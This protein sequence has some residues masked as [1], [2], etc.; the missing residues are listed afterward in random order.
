M[1]NTNTFTGYYRPKQR[2]KYAGD[3]RNIYYRSSWERHFCK[4]C[5]LNDKVKKWAIEPF[6][7]PYFDEGTGKQRKYNPDFWVEM[8]DGTVY[9]IEVKPKYETEPPKMKEG[10]KRF[11]LAEQTFKTNSSKWAAATELCTK[12]GWIFK[13]V[14]EVTLEEMG[15]KLIAQPKRKKIG[16]NKSKVKYTNKTSRKKVQSKGKHRIQR[17]TVRK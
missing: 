8:K 17:R 7:I 12:K 2:S 9:L 15:I 5:D 6:K 10:T 3:A 11:L 4:W 1:A 14:T 16:T 13:V